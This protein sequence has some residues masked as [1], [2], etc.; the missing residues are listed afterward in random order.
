MSCRLGGIVA[1]RNLAGIAPGHR[2]STEVDSRPRSLVLPARHDAPTLQSN[3][4]LE[5]FEETDLLRQ[6]PPGILAIS[7]R[8]RRSREGWSSARGI[9]TPEMGGM[10][11]PDKARLESKQGSLRQSPRQLD[12]FKSNVMLQTARCLCAGRSWARRDT[13]ITT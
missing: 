8:Y 9:E 2:A 5:S 12:R 13:S 7:R 11:L 4:T 6:D 10:S 3:S 1:E